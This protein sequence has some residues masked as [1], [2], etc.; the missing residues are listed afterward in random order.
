MVTDMQDRDAIV[1]NA[2]E[3]AS[4][5]VRQAY[6][7]GA[8]GSDAAL[9]RQVEERVAAH[10]ASAPPGPRP[11]R[12]EPAHAGAHR[13][14]A[15]ETPAVRTHDIPQDLDND[16]ME[17]RKMGQKKPRGLMTVWALLLLP[18]TVG[19]AGLTV[20]KMHSDNPEQKSAQQIQEERDQALKAVEAS[21]KQLETAVAARQALEKER[22]QA[23]A[24][25]KVARQSEQTSKAVLSFLQDR[26]LLA[27]GNPAAWNGDTLVKAGEDITLRKAVDAAEAKVSG[28]FTDKPLVEASIRQILGATY[29][30]L[31]QTGRA[32]Q[33]YKQAMVLLQGELDPDHPEIGEC[34]KRLAV[35]LKRD[36][37][38]NEADHLFDLSVPTKKK[39]SIKSKRGPVRGHS[40][41]SEEARAFAE[42]R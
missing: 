35:A 25:E 21:K 10:F 16:S 2:I 5:A 38:A 12:R 3:I 30:D 41:V 27:T 4:A 29:L 19:G 24:A 28:T 18:A 6:I 13:D 26:L 33:Q 23:M 8:C 39:S 36:N 14:G 22:D 37:R 42:D 11:P 15:G 7:A 40:P 20:W 1:S 9:R 34:R 32:V 31:G 17:V